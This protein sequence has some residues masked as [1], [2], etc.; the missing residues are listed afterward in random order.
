M[1]SRRHLNPDQFG[2]LTFEHSETPRE[3]SI[4]AYHPDFGGGS[5]PVGSMN[6]AKH[7][8][9]QFGRTVPAGHIF[10]I[11]VE[12]SFQKNGIATEMFR[13][14][15]QHNPPPVHSP[16]QTKAGKKFAKKTGGA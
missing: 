3:H 16:F 5:V 15:G 1:S 4:D 14:A 12:S 6:W 2:K 8:D 11:Q 9:A 7:T 10:N 13:R